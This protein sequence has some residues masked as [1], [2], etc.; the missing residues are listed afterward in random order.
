MDDAEPVRLA[1]LSCLHCG[2]REFDPELMERTVSGVNRSE[3]D[4][5]LVAGNLTEHG[6]EWEYGE[7]GEYLDGIEAP[8]IVVPGSDDSRNVGYVHY[9]RMFGERHTTHRLELEGARAE[10]LETDGITV[11]AL[12]SSEPD[13]SM[14]R[15]GREW[16]P[17]LRERLDVPGD[18]TVVLLHHHVVAIPGAGRETTVVEDAGD[19]L[20]I[21]SDLAVDVILTGSRHVPF[22]W[23]LNGM[24]VCNSGTAGSRR[25]RGSVPPSWNELE[26]DAERIRIH[27]HYEDGTRQ[28]AAV[29]SRAKRLVARAGFTVTDDFFRSNHLPVG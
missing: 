3:P 22:F 15:I 11:V 24:L 25:L 29:R 1:H 17:W 14:G 7:A 28:L 5:A 8:V 4:V 20:A 9:Q 12:D 23:G 21:L 10:A 18:L 26:I 16:Y 2:G 19:L 13:L 27:V 6:Y